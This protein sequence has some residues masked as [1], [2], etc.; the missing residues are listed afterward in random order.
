MN[1][2]FQLELAYDAPLTK[3]WYALTDLQSMKRWYFPQIKHFDLKVGSTF[4]FVD[5]GAIYKKEW[6]ITRLEKN[7]I[8]A[9]SWLYKGYP[10][11]SEV[12]F[13]LSEKDKMTSLRLTHTCKFQ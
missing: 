9:Y 8:L 6:T 7:K 11:C 3:V 4:G 13:E 2:S 5:D 1:D 12:T 10:G